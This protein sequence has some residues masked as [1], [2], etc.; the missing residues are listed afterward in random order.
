M[1]FNFLIVGIRK[2]GRWQSFTNNT[3]LEAT[4]LAGVQHVPWYGFSLCSRWFGDKGKL[5]AM[6]RSQLKSN[7]Q[8]ERKS[9]SLNWVATFRH[10]KIKNNSRFVPLQQ[11]YVYRGMNGFEELTSFHLQV[12]IKQIIHFET[13]P[14]PFECAEHYIALVLNSDIQF[15]RAITLGQCKIKKI[16]TC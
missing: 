6:N 3:V 7:L 12:P 4:Q 2:C 9:K 5:S 1:F 8:I 15:L 13:Q 16:L 14:A 10:Y 11:V